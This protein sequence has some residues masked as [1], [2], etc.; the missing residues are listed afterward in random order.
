[1]SAV[2]WRVREEG[3]IVH[4]E[5][6]CRDAYEAIEMAEHIAEGIRNGDLTLELHD[7]EVKK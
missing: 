6:I 3:K 7:R 1:M 4:L 5:I 2:R